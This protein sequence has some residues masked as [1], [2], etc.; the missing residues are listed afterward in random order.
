ML[1]F[2]LVNPVVTYTE[3]LSTDETL[4]GQ[5][6][7][8]SLLLPSQEGVEPSRGLGLT[9]GGANKYGTF[10]NPSYS[11]TSSHGAPDQD[12]DRILVRL[13]PPPYNKVTHPVSPAFAQGKG[14]R[15]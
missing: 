5:P 12:T 4:E 13:F 9:V 11:P 3:V 15:Q 1:S 8:T 14:G 7:S 2:A 10:D 6:T